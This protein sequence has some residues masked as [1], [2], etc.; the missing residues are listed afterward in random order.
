LLL[1]KEEITGLDTFL[2]SYDPLS[3]YIRNIKA[4]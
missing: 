3:A 2:Q 4:N 1:V